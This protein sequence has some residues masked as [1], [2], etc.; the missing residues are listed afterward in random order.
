MKFD[1]FMNTLAQSARKEQVAGSSPRDAVLRRLHGVG[2][3]TNEEGQKSLFLA[4]A[5]TG[6]AACISLV[7]S[8]EAYSILTDPLGLFIGILGYLPL[9]V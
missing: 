2:A 3:D 9:G 1:D 6:A 7:V 4:V 8:L 5:I